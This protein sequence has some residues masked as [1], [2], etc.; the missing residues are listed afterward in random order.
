M[1][2]GRVGAHTGLSAK[3]VLLIDEVGAD[4]L[5]D[6][7]VDNLTG[8]HIIKYFPIRIIDEI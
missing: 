5:V 6:I 3:L 7:A 4:G 2:I 1:G 8:I